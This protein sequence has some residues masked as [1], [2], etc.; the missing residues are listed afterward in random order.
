MC[1]LGITQ[2]GICLNR[3]SKTIIRNLFRIN[4]KNTRRTSVDFEKVNTGWVQAYVPEIF[5]MWVYS[6]FCF[7]I[8][9]DIRLISHEFRLV[10][11]ASNIIPCTIEKLYCPH[12]I[13]YAQSRRGGCYCSISY[14]QR[15]IEENNVYIGLL[16]LLH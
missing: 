8:F 5:C 15:K 9:S 3:N 10:Y 2:V 6:S 13:T 4:N 14:C 16:V 12:V 1:P 7:F 11:V